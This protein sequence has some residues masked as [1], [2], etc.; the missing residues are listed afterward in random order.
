MIH[1]GFSIANVIYYQSV[2]VALVFLTTLLFVFYMAFLCVY[3]YECSKQ[4][5]LCSD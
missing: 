5:H 3:V 4:N 2:A 1:F